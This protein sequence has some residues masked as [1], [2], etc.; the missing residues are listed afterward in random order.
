MNGIC[1]WAGWLSANGGQLCFLTASADEAEMAT[2]ATNGLI[3]SV[4]SKAV[5]QAKASHLTSQAERTQL[6]NILH[7]ANDEATQ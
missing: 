2:H 5:L 4:C 1:A 6:M 3:D 7:R